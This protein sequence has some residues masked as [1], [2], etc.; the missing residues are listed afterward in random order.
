MKQGYSKA[1][2]TQMVMAATRKELAGFSGDAAKVAAAQ[3]SAK[4]LF[5]SA[6]GRLAAGASGEAVT[7]A[8]QEATAYLGATLGSD[9]QF[10]WTEMNDRLINAAI[11]G[12]TLGGAFSIPGAAID[13]GAW[14]DVAYRTAPA[15]E[16]RLSDA[17]RWAEKEIQEHGRVKSVSELNLES[18]TF[19]DN[20]QVVSLDERVDADRQRRKDRTFEEKIS[21][22]ALATPGLWRGVIRHIIPQ[23]V[24]DQ[25]RAARKLADIFGGQ[26]QKTFS[27]ASYENEKFHR[28][29]IYKNMVDLPE[30][31]FSA[32]NGGRIPSLKRKRELSDEVYTALQA[33]TNK[34]GNFDPALVPDG[35]HKQ[36]VINLQQQLQRL[37]N[38]MYD[39][40]KKHNPDLG[41]IKNYLARYKSFDKS[42]IAKNKEAFVQALLNKKE[43]GGTRAE[44]IALADEIIGNAEVNDF[45]EAFSAVKGE[46]KP[47]SHQERTLNLAEDA[48]FAPFMERDIFANVSNA[49]RSAAR[50]TTHQDYVGRNGEKVAALLQEMQQEG[51]DADTVN[52]IAAGMKDFLDAESGNYKRAQSKAGKQLEKI[53]RNFMFI[54]MIAGL[55]LATISSFVEL[56]LTMRGLTSDQVFG[57]GGLKTIGKELAD[58]LN[59]GMDEIAS[60]RPGGKYKDKPVSQGKHNLRRLGFYE[61]DVGAAT[62]TGATEISP[63]RQRFTEVYFKVTGLS[64]WTN[65]T[66]AVR[67]SIGA[68]YI[69]DKLQRIMD[70]DPDAPTNES[71][72]AREALRNIGVNVDDMLNIEQA[73]M[74]GTLTPEMEA[75]FEENMREGLFNFVNDAVALPQSANRPLIYQDP[76]FALFTQ[77]QGFIATF[78]ANHIPKLWGEYVKR[79]TPAMKYNAFAIMTMMI[80]LGFASQYLKDLI[81]YGSGENPYLED[82]E[83]IQRGI[84]ASGLLGT[85]ERLLDQ[86]APIYETRSRNPV[87]WVYNQTTGEAPALGN[88]A[89]I[90]RGA[91]KALEGDIEGGVY[92]GLKAAPFIA[93]L[94]GVNKGLAGLITRGEWDFNGDK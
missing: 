16:K 60:Y 69:L 33:A 18:S 5:K 76:R 66:R 73:M 12:G 83:Y 28:V 44:A 29:A 94:T 6:A 15:E 49:V 59:L 7:E 19:L 75:Q 47:P 46:F 20:N 52:K 92:Q 35:P 31:V 36:L 45:G 21:E 14:A 56:A 65:Y 57:K 39:D 48:E 27:G 71:Q 81:K 64:G 78:T 42:A 88:V 87:D 68:D 54:T 2:A 25:S 82:P 23:H 90:A 61:W 72:E 79:G 26:L 77:F 86:F 32:L 63:L 34:E 89:R 91:G 62:V 8:T 58:T 4:N 51:V 1:D 13:A 37:S 22:A 74:N 55:P 24:K 9:K 53:Q 67:A 17:G 38:K 80:A 10:D 43:Y 40:Q 85:G 11:A 41:Y 3:L 93:P 70:T 50:Y 30:R 84:R